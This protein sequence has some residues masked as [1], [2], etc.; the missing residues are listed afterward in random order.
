[1]KKLTFI[2]C[3]LH[4]L[5]SPSGVQAQCV[6]VFTAPQP[7]TQGLSSNGWLFTQKDTLHVLVIFR[8][9]NNNTE[10]WDVG[11]K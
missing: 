4:F 11:G 1:M 7:S 8:T 9:F 3:V 10:D 5:C 6:P 2:L